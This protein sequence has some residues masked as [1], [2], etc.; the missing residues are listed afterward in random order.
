M[1]RLH[2][3]ALM[4]L[5]LALTLGGCVMAPEPGPPATVWVPGH[6]VPGPYGYHWVPP[7]Y[8]WVP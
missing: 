4:L 3:G 7:H 6:W 8:R 5:L 1:S 2:R